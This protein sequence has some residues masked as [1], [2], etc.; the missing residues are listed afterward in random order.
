MSNMCNTYAT[1]MKNVASAKYLPGHMLMTAEFSPR[2]PTHTRDSVPTPKSEDH[3]CGIDRVCVQLAVLQESFGQKPI[4]V[5][6]PLV[7]VCNR[8]MRGVRGLRSRNCQKP[9]HARRTIH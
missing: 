4:W 1:K 6:V 2:T 3:P 7:V 9:T 8:P 5:W